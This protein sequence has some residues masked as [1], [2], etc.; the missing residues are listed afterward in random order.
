MRK[1][2]EEGKFLEANSLMYKALIDKNYKTTLADMRVLGCVNLVFQ[3]VGIYSHYRRVLHMDP[4]ELE[5]TYKLDGA[6]YKRKTAT[7]LSSRFFMG[8]SHLQHF[9]NYPKY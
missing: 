3:N 8:D 4:S 6:E 5:I 7:R 1:L 2:Q 9:A